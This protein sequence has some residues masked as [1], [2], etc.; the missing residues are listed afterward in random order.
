MVVQINYYCKGEIIEWKWSSDSKLLPAPFW[1]SCFLIDGLL[2][3]SGAPGGED[4]LRKFLLSL[5]EEKMVKKCVITH[6]HEDHCG[7]AAMLR[8]EFK[9]PIYSSEK[10]I[11][12]LKKQ[13]NYP[14][15]RRITWGFPYRPFEAKPIAH[16]IST[17]SNKYTFEIIEIPGHAVEEI[18]LLE[19]RKEWAII[20]DGIMPKYTMIFGKSTD[21]PEDIHQ[22]YNSLK[23]LENI[24]KT[25]DNLIILTAGRGVFKNRV[26]IKE[27]IQEI[28]KLHK[29]AF[30][31]KKEAE[32]KSYND[33]RILRYITRKMF[34]KESFIGQLTRGGL[35]NQN[36]IISLLEW[37][38]K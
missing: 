34:N 13:K 22:I 18:A 26:I 15:Y 33:K 12:L 5:D 17:C 20:A 30:K 31:Y 11:P 21:I 19:R 4:D 6:S 14:D 37:P 35:S 23:K 25:M 10:T 8:S 9:I 3:D 1:T 32:D 2:I 27:K 28:E 24:T 29:M 38:L 36:L 16:S 7:G